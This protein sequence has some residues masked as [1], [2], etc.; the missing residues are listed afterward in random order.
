VADP[1]LPV[2]IA[3]SRETCTK[4]VHD[5]ILSSSPYAFRQS[6]AGYSSFRL[7]VSG[8]LDVHAADICLVGS[9]QLGFS[10]NPGHLLTPFRGS[11]DLFG[12]FPT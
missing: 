3:A 10:L 5:W 7:E 1:L 8:M 9:G 12:P 11:S 4:F 2:K 6:N